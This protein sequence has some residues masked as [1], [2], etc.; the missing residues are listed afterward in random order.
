MN[1]PG[2]LKQFNWSISVSGNILVINTTGK[3]HDLGA[4]SKLG[5]RGIVGNFS[6]SSRRRMR[7]YL[8]ETETDFYSMLT[9]TYPPEIGRYE[10]RERKN[11][12][13]VFIQ[14]IRRNAERRYAG[15]KQ[16]SAFWFLEFQKNGSIHYHLFTTHGYRQCDIQRYWA[17]AATRR[18]CAD[19][20]QKIWEQIYRTGSRIERVRSGRSGISR[21]AAKYAAKFDQKL[22]PECFKDNGAGRFWGVI[23]RGERLSAAT[24]C[25]IDVESFASVKAMRNAIDLNIKSMIAEGI[26]VNINDKLELPEGINVFDVRDRQKSRE[27]QELIECLEIIIMI[28][29]GKTHA[30]YMSDSRLER[31]YLNLSRKWPNLFKQVGIDKQEYDDISLLQPAQ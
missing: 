28:I 30:R 1:L 11:D 16:F 29:T 15:G 26:V 27:L 2:K 18:V 6:D 23:N 14:R 24:R 17:D 22:V 31:N 8:R 12:L 10:A 25:G 13:R 4:D 21:Y 5:N 20:K 7:K 19:K 3:R 9:L